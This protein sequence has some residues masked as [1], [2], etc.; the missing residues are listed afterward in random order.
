MTE[1]EQINWLKI[2]TGLLI[3]AVITT[4]PA[5][6]QQSSGS[7][8]IHVVHTA[9]G[10]P[11][12]LHEQTYKNAFGESYSL[13]KLRYYISQI[14]LT[15]SHSR[16]V[17]DSYHLIDL[18]K[19][20]EPIMLSCDTGRYIQ[21]DFLLGIDSAAHC[22]GAQTGALDPVNDMFWTWN[23][24]YV[25]FKLEGESSASTADLNRIEHHI[26]GYKGEQTV[27]SAVSLKTSQVEAIHIR[28]G[29][30][31]HV[32]IDMNLDHYWTGR[33]EVRISESP[34]CTT[35]GALAKKISTNFPG[36]F[37]IQR[38]ENAP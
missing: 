19:E 15:G 27:S 16:E 1:R 2:I 9:N 5:Q 4:R 12:V 36:L 18:S 35:T 20:Q 26:G 37:S 29:Q 13:R 23:S 31:T 34:L 22:S 10:Q 17:G 11:L 32:Y 8:A 7:M 14:G 38:I 30:I 6:A 21:L 25:I 24:G 33:S 3:C 28:P